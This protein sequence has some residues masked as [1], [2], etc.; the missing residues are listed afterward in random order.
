[1]SLSI[2]KPSGD[3]EI[4]PTENA[5]IFCPSALKIN[6]PEDSDENQQLMQKDLLPTTAQIYSDMSKN[7]NGKKQSRLTF[8]Q[9]VLSHSSL[10]EKSELLRRKLEQQ[11][12]NLQ[13]AVVVSASTCFMGVLVAGGIFSGSLA[14]LSRGVYLVCQVFGTITW[15]CTKSSD[16]PKG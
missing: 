5:E 4:R 16:Y 7:I 12:E 6:E 11:T 14:V 2:R 9:D 10:T 13:T 15:A 8:I 3:H 1:M